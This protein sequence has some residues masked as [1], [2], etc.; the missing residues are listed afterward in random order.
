MSIIENLYALEILDSR[1][2]PTVEAFIQVEGVW[3]QASVP[4]GASTGSKEAHELRDTSKK[5]FLGFGVN[6]AVENINTAIAQSIVGKNFESQSDLDTVLIDLDGSHNKS[7][8]G[9]N[10]I[11]AVSLAFAQ[12]QAQLSKK[13]LYQFLQ[14]TD[15][16]S[17]PYPL[18]NFINGGA[19][20]NNRLEFQE[21]MIIPKG[22][23]KFI[24]AIEKSAEVFYTL[25]AILSK[26]GYP[27]TVGD[28][29][30]Y[31]PPI[32]SNK[33]A[34]ELLLEA[35]EQAGYKTPDDFTLALDCASTEFYND[36]YYHFEQNKKFNSS[37]FS[38]Y[39]GDLINQYPIS[40]IEDGM[41]EQDYDGWAELTANYKDKVQLVGDDLFV[42]NY[43]ILQEGIKK[44][45]ANSILIKLNQ[46]GTLTETLSTIALAQK[47]NYSTIISHRS[48][49]TSNTFI[50]DLAV[51]TNSG[52]IK[53]GSLSRSERTSKYNKL[54]W[55]EYIQQKQNM[56]LTFKKT[57]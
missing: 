4:S 33:E 32:D 56:P 21:F 23:T 22:E 42:T 17:L 29:G 31:A 7:H 45:I 14:T 57:T 18:L 28:E 24:A 47:N 3:S 43:E 15:T 44:N 54:L 39:L 13:P 12:A 11:L 46:I 35:I 53:T 27:T 8:L 41:A 10:S 19:H 5:R 50:S 48:G 55:I 34:L 51:A 9:A 26:K 40:S 38:N 16:L 25:K 30:G 6:Q 49:E 2:K 52:Q 20:A 1:G 37:Q 36:N